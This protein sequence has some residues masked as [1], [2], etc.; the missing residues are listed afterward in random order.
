MQSS[1]SNP[2]PNK[3]I[4]VVKSAAE[5]DDA[6][7]VHSCQDTP[8]TSKAARPNEAKVDL[9]TKVPDIKTNRIIRGLR[10]MLSRFTISEEMY[11]ELATIVGGY[12]RTNGERVQ[13]VQRKFSQWKDAGTLR[14]QTNV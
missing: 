6:Q 10:E 3:P 4:A 11:V 2:A 1:C 8:L 9:G 5:I 12:Y 13:A 7:T 14:L